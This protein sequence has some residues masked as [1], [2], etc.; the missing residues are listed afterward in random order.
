MNLMEQKISKLNNKIKIFR[1]YKI[2]LGDLYEKYE[3]ISDDLTIGNNQ[4]VDNYVKKLDEIEK[5]LSKYDQL[6]NILI[7]FDGMYGEISSKK[8]KEE[9]IKNMVKHITNN[10]G[11][12]IY[13]YL[14]NNQDDIKK[15][16]LNRIYKIIY[17]VMKLEIMYLN[18][19]NLFNYYADK[20]FSKQFLKE[21]IKEDLIR[22]QNKF[23]VIKD[24]D[25]DNEYSLKVLSI[26]I[27]NCYS[28]E[29]LKLILRYDEN[30]KEYK[31]RISN[32]FKELI[33]RHENNSN[34]FAFK[35][36]NIEYNKTYLE[37]LKEKLKQNKKD[38][39][40]R[41]KS[42][43]L[44]LTLLTGFF[45]WNNSNLKKYS[46]YKVY[47]GTE[48]SYS[49]DY[50]MKERPIE[51]D[52]FSNPTDSIK[53]NEYSKVFDNQR[54]ISTYDVSDITLNDIKDYL[55][56]NLDDLYYDISLTPY[57]DDTPNFEYSEVVITDIN[58]NKVYE[59]FNSSDYYLYATLYILFSEILY[60]L[61]GIFWK[62]V[63]KTKIYTGVIYN[64]LKIFER[65]SYNPSL[66]E[67]YKNNTNEIKRTISKIEEI[68]SLIDKL[69]IEDE[70]LKEKFNELYQQY[71][72]L[73]KE[74]NLFL[75]R[76]EAI[77]K[78]NDS[79]KLVRRKDN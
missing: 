44:T 31:N 30:N 32:K 63:G 41:I 39:H 71:S 54:T 60:D 52:I 4:E 66:Y 35:Q 61:L 56:I 36:D 62:K 5:E 69:E 16:L 25:F 21:F 2:D 10:L 20:V 28:L 1:Q 6:L 17:D 68:K 65:E 53:I 12:I 73:L 40:L 24:E 48:K 9:S 76:F 7:V 27:G 77:D 42:I 58:D 72:Y 29:Y 57:E 51:L 8:N 22:I 59:N 74:A 45:Y 64:L 55:D 19:E 11:N 34:D 50:G 49:T 79:K 70:E 14:K 47:K 37:Q 3:K 38:I 26:N 67:K 23:S 15:Q 43:V 18:E 78:Q 33:N 75:N 46:T 13:T